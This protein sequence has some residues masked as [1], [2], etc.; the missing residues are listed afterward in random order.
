MCYRIV[1]LC[2][3]VLVLFSCRER[4]TP[5]MP[6]DGVTRQGNTAF[7]YAQIDVDAQIFTVNNQRD[8]LLFGRKGLI[9]YVPAN[10]FVSKRNRG[11]MELI[12][13]EYDQPGAALAQNISNNSNQKDLLQYSKI[14]HLDARQGETQL[15]LAPENDLMV[16]FKREEDDPP[17]KL[18]YGTP[19]AWRVLKYDEPKLFSHVLTIGPYQ[20][21]K[22]TNRQS[23][24]SWEAVHFKLSPEEENRIWKAR[25]HLHLEW[26]LDK[27]G[28]AKNW[29]FRE[30][31]DPIVEAR[32]LKTVQNYPNCIP[33][34]DERGKAQA[35]DMEFAFHVY[36]SEPN[37]T[38]NLNYLT[39]W[40]KPYAALKKCNL[41]HV[42]DVELNYHIYNLYTL[43]WIAAA[44]KVQPQNAVDLMVKLEPSVLAEVKL[45]LQRSKVVLQG[46]RDGDAVRF[47][48]LPKDEP[49]Q[50]IAFGHGPQ[51]VLWATSNA[52]SSDGIVSGLSFE[53]SSYDDIKL[54][55]AKVH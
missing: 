12:L 7:P 50:I 25:K 21:I 38:R 44:A 26:T 52:N 6:I 13:K 1:S 47:E 30:Q 28:Q 37:Y 55:L 35:V 8:T 53:P 49:L 32:I 18:W 24:E 31:I 54:A 23:S 45:F 29:R 41:N 5:P 27:N 46:K 19:Q 51:Q 4:K 48:G 9:I 14:I 15:K 2:L 22:F 43:G 11:N 3:I 36:E 16:H 33:Y 20:D 34:K 17:L 10:T 40:G 39:I 42:D